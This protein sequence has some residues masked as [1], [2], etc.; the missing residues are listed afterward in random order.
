MS[1]RTLELYIVHEYVIY[2]VDHYHVVYPLN[3]VLTIAV[4]P[5]GAYFLNMFVV[6]YVE[7]R[8]EKLPVLV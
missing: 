1:Q 2:T 3:I 5:L 4:I 6:R 7:G 8:L